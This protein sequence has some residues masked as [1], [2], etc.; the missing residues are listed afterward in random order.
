M[1]VETHRLNLFPS[2]LLPNNRD[3]NIHPTD[4][5][6]MNMY[7]YSSLLPLSGTTTTVSENLIPSQPPP[8]NPFISDN[9]L[10]KISAM[11][12]DSILTCNNNNNNVVS[13]PRKRSRDSINNY[14]FVSYK[15]SGNFSFLGED[16]SENINH[17]NTYIDSIISQHM[18]KVRVELE[19]KR[20]RQT[21]LIMEA[22]MKRL[23]A[24]EEEIKKIE[25]MNM[26]LEER[27]K[28]LC[29]ENQIWRE[30]A[31]SKEATA[32]ALRNNLEQV[33]EQMT[34]GGGEDAPVAPEE[35]AE[36]C[37]GSNDENFRWRTVADCA[38]DKDE[39]RVMMM[40]G[41]CSEKKRLC[42]N[43]GKGESCVLILPC[44]HLCLCTMCGATV[45]TCPICKSFKNASYQVNL[46]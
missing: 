34:N 42:R 26:M 18:E 24:K 17:Q 40:N 44:R 29:M 13:F 19:E 14:P 30:I 37:C 16:F 43:C 46:S 4:T 45:H 39:G 15:N 22:M 5:S 9:L 41:G 33:L 20:K 12:S 11:K 25:I 6:F 21:R 32:N 7:N 28:S 27:A 10:Q 38:Q 36:S 2:Q 35:D 31:Q 8:Y 23:K 1:T 3:M